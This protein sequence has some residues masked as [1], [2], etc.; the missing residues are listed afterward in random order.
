M[1]L[2]GEKVCR[3]MQEPPLTLIICS[4]DRE[5]LRTSSGPVYWRDALGVSD[6]THTT[7]W[8]HLGNLPRIYPRPINSEFLGIWPRPGYFSA[9]PSGDSNVHLV[10][11]TAD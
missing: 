10:L 1:E 2:G 3:R 5:H 6:L 8:N 4:G 11:R 7:Y 9:A